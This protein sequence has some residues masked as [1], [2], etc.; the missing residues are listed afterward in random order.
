MATGYEAPRTAP[1]WWSRLL[2]TGSLIVAAATAYWSYSQLKDLPT[3]DQMVAMIHKGTMGLE[4]ETK[5]AAALRD[6]KVQ[7]TLTA[8]QQQARSVF[9]EHQRLM[10]DVTTLKTRMD[11]DL[12]TL[13]NKIE[14]VDTVQDESQNDM[15]D[16]VAEAATDAAAAPKDDGQASAAGSVAASAGP[17]P[18][19][20]TESGAPLLE[21]QQ[22]TLRPVATNLQGVLPFSIRNSGQSVAEIEAVE[23]RPKEVLNNLPL[24]SLDD[25]LEESPDSLKV[26]FHPD[27]NKTT[28]SGHHGRYRTATVEGERLLPDSSADLCVVIDDPAHAGFGFRGELTI[29][30]RGETEPLKIESFP[31]LFVGTTAPSQP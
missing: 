2:A 14:L 7:Q 10:Q 4:T 26:V 23:F 12:A 6:Q 22:M 25:L 1:D 30:Y 16:Q 8:V 28:Q 20:L 19:T 9:D 13:E 29:H 5:D 18:D 15:V 11:A 31:V 3:R 21:A 24:V 17:S 27:D